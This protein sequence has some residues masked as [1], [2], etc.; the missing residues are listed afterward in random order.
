MSTASPRATLRRH[1]R[2]TG[3]LR[4]RDIAMTGQAV[5][6]PPFKLLGKVMP[7]AARVPVQVA[8][9]VPK[10][11]LPSAVDRNRVRRHMRESYRLGKASIHEHLRARG[12]QCAWL[13]IYQGRTTTDLPST[14]EKISR[15]MDRW[16][17]EHLPA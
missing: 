4:I 9:A 6:I 16:L 7:L 12:V 2:L 14:R 13:F 5:S 3:A 1:E 15:A 11:N 17:H 10:R 8:F